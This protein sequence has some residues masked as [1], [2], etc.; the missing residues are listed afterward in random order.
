MP[1]KSKAMQRLMYASL[2][3]DTGVPK[4]VAEKMIKETP[5]AS[6]SKLREYVKKKKK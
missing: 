3:S 4:K 2:K 5:K 1:I 6:F